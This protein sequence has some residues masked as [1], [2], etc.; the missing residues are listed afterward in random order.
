MT[1]TWKVLGQTVMTGAAGSVYSPPD[2][3]TRASV[4]AAQL[5]NPTGGAIVVNVFLVPSGGSATDAT[6]VDR[7]TVP[8]TSA[9]TIFGLINQKVNPGSSIRASGNGVTITI[10]GSE[11]V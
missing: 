9:K 10:S 6:Q 4:S 5:W 8:A 3:N 7:V 11:S 2:S 1:I